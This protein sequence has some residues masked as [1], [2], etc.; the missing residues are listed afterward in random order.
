MHFSLTKNPCNVEDAVETLKKIPLDLVSWTVKNSRRT[1][2]ELKPEP[3]AEY[4]K[5][6][7]A[8]KPLPFDERPLHIWSGNSYRLDGGS[9]GMYGEDGTF[10]LLPYWM[11]RYW[12]I[13]EE[14]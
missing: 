1:D 2:V 8:V 6:K 12:S 9:G 10:F 4:L 14:R 13:I 7:E 3:E 5:V 11:G